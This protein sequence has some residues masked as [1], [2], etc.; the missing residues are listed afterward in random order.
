MI[1]NEVSRRFAWDA[2]FAGVTSIN[3]HP[4]AGKDIGHGMAQKMSIEECAKVADEM[5]AERDK[6][7][8]R[9]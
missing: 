5:L 3:F 9:D 4:G 8:G 6:R 2:Y 1:E 7:F